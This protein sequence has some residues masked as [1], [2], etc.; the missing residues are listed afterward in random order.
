MSGDRLGKAT[1]LDSLATHPFAG[2]NVWRILETRAGVSHEKDFLVWNPYQSEVRTWTYGKFARDAAAVGAGLTA[3]GVAPGDRVL[4]HLENCPEFLMA[5]FA[6][7]AIGAIAVTTNTHSATDELAFYADDC[8]PVGVI[9]Q[10]RFVQ[11]IAKVVRDSTWIVCTDNNSGA[12]AASNDLPG[13]SDSFAAL[14]GDP[15]ELRPVLADPT[16]PMCVMYTSGTTSRP[17]G[18]VWTHANVCWCARLQAMSQSLTE[19]DRHFVCLPLFHSGGNMFGVLP[20]LWV[21][22][23]FVL[24]PKWSTSRFWDISFRHRPTWLLL[25][26]PSWRLLQSSIADPPRNHPYRM[27]GGV[28]SDTPLDAAYGTKSVGCFAMTE[29]IAP[30]IAGDPYFPNRPMSAGRP[31]PGYEIAVVR[32]DGVTRTDPEETGQLLVRGTRGVSIFAE[33]LNNPRATSDA[34]DERGWF[35]TGDLVTV[36]SDGFI[37]YS[38]RMKDMLKVGAEN[39]AASEVERV[40]ATVPGV[41]ESAVVGRPDEWL[42]EVPVAFVRCQQPVPGIAD[43]IR[44]TC[45][46]RLADFKVPREI[47]VVPEFPRSSLGKISKVQLRRATGPDA[48]RETLMRRWVE[49]ATTDPSSR[50]DS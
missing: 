4:I 30:P 15:T 45:A 5:W 19:G 46:A 3:R 40:I 13:R 42:D 22:A 39:V 49:M 41:I 2:T 21:G 26:G 16:A 10:P 38:D 36:H 1:T 29:L 32:E 35:L 9:T 23:S 47:V 6:C 28:Y 11:E 34:F 37:S 44:Q 31:V 25:F 33:Y 48:D 50:D 7:A 24:V 14:L 18:V 8:A 20:T 27:F 17:K 12:P 43:L